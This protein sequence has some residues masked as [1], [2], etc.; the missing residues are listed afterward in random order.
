MIT[1]VL[2]EMRTPLHDGAENGHDSVVEI[3]IKLGANVNVEVS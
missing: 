3:L 2:Q 1:F